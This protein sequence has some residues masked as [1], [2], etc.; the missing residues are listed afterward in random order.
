M[1]SNTAIGYRLGV[2][3]RA[4]AAIFGGYALTAAAIALLAIWLPLARAEA[5]LT[6]TMLSFALYATAVIWVFAARSAWRAWFGMLVPTI[7]LG[8]LLLLTRSMS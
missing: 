4:V 7:V 8:S 3:S 2:A 6:A 5:V 1:K